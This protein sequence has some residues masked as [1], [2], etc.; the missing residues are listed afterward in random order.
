MTVRVGV[1]AHAGPFWA[2]ASKTVRRRRHHASG[3]AVS[4]LILAVILHAHIGI[5][6]WP[7]LAAFTVLSVAAGAVIS[8]RQSGKHRL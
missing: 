1:G 4:L 2:S 3:G 5:W 7:V 8:R 6:A